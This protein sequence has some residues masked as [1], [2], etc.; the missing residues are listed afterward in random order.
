[1][2]SKYCRG[3]LFGLCWLWPLT[4]LAV[5]D[6][7]WLYEVEGPVAAQTDE[8][9]DRA[10]SDALLVVLTRLTGLTSVPRSPVIGAA[11]ARP[12]DYYNQ[13]VFFV[14]D[15]TGAEQIYLRVTFQADAVLAL[16]EKAGLPVW[17][18]KRANMLA[19]I[20]VDNGG[21]REIL[22]STSQHPLVAGLKER[23]RQRGIPIILPLMDLDDQLAVTAGDIWGKLGQT[24]DA[25]A[26]RYG[27]EL[28]LI[29]RIS[30]AQTSF[31]D[32]QPF[33]GDWEIWLDGQP[34]AENFTA[35]SAEDAANVGIDLVADRLAERYAVLPRQLRLRQMT[36]TGLDDGASYANFMQY[37][38]SLEFIDHVDVTAIDAAKL[39][40]ALA[41][42]AQMEQLLMLL[43]AQGR[44]TEDKLYRGIGRQLIWRG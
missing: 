29:G 16:I 20:V 42:R 9:R 34:V 35:R 12:S 32:R 22:T 28:V 38:A 4:S 15:D 30:R 24:L 5:A 3:V 27:A 1:V 44:L 31:M 33:R 26:A 7:A 36:I 13:F 41:S 6:A 39:H 11:L 21:N 43:T 18:S 2:V 8:E 19:W 23:A 37:L 40:I 25:G 10:A 17:W 14:N